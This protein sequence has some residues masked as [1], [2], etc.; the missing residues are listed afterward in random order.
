MFAHLLRF[1]QGRGLLEASHAGG[2]SGAQGDAAAFASFDLPLHW[3]L[4]RT[5][6]S[7]R[8]SRVKGSFSQVYWEEVAAPA[9]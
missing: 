5:R 1:Q 3:A 6:G 4:L 9:R 2:L 7:C 8:H